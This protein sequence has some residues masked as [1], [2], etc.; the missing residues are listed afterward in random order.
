[1]KAILESKLNSG[2]TV[3]AL[4]TWTAP[5]IRYSTGRVDL[6]NSELCNM[7]RKTRKVLNMYQV[8]CPKIKCRET[9]LTT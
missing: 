8:L 1:M 2:N 7:D 5:V 9:R 3:K 4:N 6:N